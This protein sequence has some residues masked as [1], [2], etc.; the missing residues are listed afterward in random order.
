L[1]DLYST[2]KEKKKRNYILLP[3]SSF[4]IVVLTE[5]LVQLQRRKINLLFI[6]WHLCNSKILNS[7]YNI[8]KVKNAQYH[9]GFKF[10]TFLWKRLQYKLFRLMNKLVSYINYNLYFNNSLLSKD[11]QKHKIYRMIQSESLIKP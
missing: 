10:E 6:F 1:A 9:N 8:Q 11:R 4:S 5:G 7:L 3:F 2:F